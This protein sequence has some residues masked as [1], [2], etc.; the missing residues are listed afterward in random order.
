MAGEPDRQLALELPFRPAMGRE[1]FIVSESNAAA[2]DAIDKLETADPPLLVVVGPEGSGKTHLGAIFQEQAGAVRAD[3]SE[4][5]E[6]V[7]EQMLSAGAGLVEGMPPEAGKPF[8]EDTFFHL[9]NAA[10]NKRLALLITA[11]NDPPAWSLKTDDVRTRLRLARVVT[12]AMPDDALFSALLLKLMADRQITV[13]ANA[14][15]YAIP[16]LERS[17]AAAEAFVKAVDTASME[18]RR[19]VTLGVVR[20]VIAG[21]NGD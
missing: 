19:T 15:R 1:D 21:M 9:I 8:A 7:M 20:E 3:A 6:A 17:H 5:S 18:K 13:A 12:L 2:V 10:I 14:L 16:R 4:L 11:R